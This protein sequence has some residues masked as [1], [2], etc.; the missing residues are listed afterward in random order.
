MPPGPPSTMPTPAA[1]DPLEPISP[2]ATFLSTEGEQQEVCDGQPPL[3]S[4]SRSSSPLQLDLLQEEMPKLLELP[5]LVP[6]KTLMETK[7]DQDGEE[8]GNNDD[9]SVSSELYDL[10][11]HEDSHSGTGSAASACG[12]AESSSL[13]SGSNGSSSN[14]TSACG[15]GLKRKC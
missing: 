4:N 15:T 12:F 11:L 9:H 8:S 5:C 1:P 13:V 3:F 10:L 14:G 2:T 6:D 7:C